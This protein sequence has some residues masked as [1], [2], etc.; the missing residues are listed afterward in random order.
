M[1]MFKI[2]KCGVQFD[3][4]GGFKKMCPKCF[5][6]SKNEE[7]ESLKRRIYE[8][9]SDRQEIDS[10]TMKQIIYLCHPD[11][12][13]NSELSNKIFCFLRGMK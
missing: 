7:L 9:E 13:N 2:C 5:A 6:K 4:G 3:D 11:K 12:H 10:Q 1:T 8:L